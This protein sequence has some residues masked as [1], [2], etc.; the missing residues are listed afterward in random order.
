MKK[1]I[2]LLLALVMAIGLLGGCD[3][4]S[5]FQSGSDKYAPYVQSLLDMAYKNKT[6]KYLE[7]VD[8]T[9]QSADEYYEEEMM[10]SWA[11]SLASYFLIE[12]EMLNDDTINQRLLDVTKE[13]FAKAKYEVAEAVKTDDYYT[14]K[15]TIEP[16]VYCELALTEAQNYSNSMVERAKSGEFG[17]VTVND[18]G[19]LSGFADDNEYVEWEKQYALGM[20][21]VM[22]SFVS[23]IEYADPVEKIVKIEEDDEGYGVDVNTLREID[24]A[25]FVWPQ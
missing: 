15:L 4:F 17:E 1:K 23:K 20:L 9:K 11:D 3:A 18:D 8:D 12:K 7:L 21:D 19:S 13:I 14:V 2:A 22:E 5:A 10:A 16:I 25:M 6:D 24:S